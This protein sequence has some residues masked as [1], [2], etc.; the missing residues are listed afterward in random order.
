MRGRQFVDALIDRA[1]VGDVLQAEVEINCFKING[2][3]VRQG[4]KQG[5]EF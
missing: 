5:A 1:R 3:L 2:W 4:G